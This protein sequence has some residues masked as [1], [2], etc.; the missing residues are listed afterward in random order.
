MLTP[1]LNPDK[2]KSVGQVRMPHGEFT[3]VTVLTL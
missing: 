2:P 1:P 3:F